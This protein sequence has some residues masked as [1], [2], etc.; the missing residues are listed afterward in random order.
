MTKTTNDLKFYLNDELEAVLAKVKTIE[1]L[2]DL[3]I[4][5]NKDRN[6]IMAALEKIESDIDQVQQL[7]GEIS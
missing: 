2:T 7:I 4:A 3:N 5:C 1:G 6:K